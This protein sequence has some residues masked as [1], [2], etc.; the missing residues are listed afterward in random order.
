MSLPVPSVLLAAVLFWL[1][2]ACAVLQSQILAPASPTITVT[3]EKPGAV[4]LPGEKI[5]WDVHVRGTV[6]GEVNTANYVLREGG[7]KIIGGGKLALSAGMGKIETSVKEP[8]TI[9]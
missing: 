2:F 3:A 1:I 5:V 8:C 6:K 9:L 7:N 4:Y